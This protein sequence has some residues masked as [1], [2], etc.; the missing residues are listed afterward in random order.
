LAALAV[1]V[2]KY[3]HNDGN[4]YLQTALIFSQMLNHKHPSIP[5][6]PALRNKKLTKAPPDQMRKE[7]IL[8][9]HLI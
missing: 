8:N 5:H 9:N 1:I 6:I 4:S 2:D 3:M 7:I